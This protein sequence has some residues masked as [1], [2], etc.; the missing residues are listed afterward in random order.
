ISKNKGRISTSQKQDPDLKSTKAGI[1]TAAQIR[2]MY[3]ILSS[4][5]SVTSVQAPMHFTD[6]RNF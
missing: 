1:N 2:P 3:N 5:L 4:F 6:Q